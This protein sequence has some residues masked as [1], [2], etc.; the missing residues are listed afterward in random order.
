MRELISGR[1]PSIDLAWEEVPDAKKSE[2]VPFGRQGAAGDGEDD[3]ELSLSSA[4]V[5]LVR[6]SEASLDQF[7]SRLGSESDEPHDDDGGPPPEKTRIEA[8]P[9]ET[10]KQ[11]EAQAARS[12]SP[13]GPGSSP[14]TPVPK[15]S[16]TGGPAR[17]PAPPTGPHR[18]SL[19]T[20]G[21]G[22]KYGD[23]A[24]IPTVIA[25]EKDGNT[26]PPMNRPSAAPGSRTPPPVRTEA[27]Y[28]P[29]MVHAAQSES[30]MAATQAAV[31][32]DPQHGAHGG[33]GAMPRPSVER[34][35]A[36]SATHDSVKLSPDQ[37]A[38]LDAP[39]G[40]S[41]QGPPPASPYP[42]VS[43][44]P[45]SSELAPSTG[46]S[47]PGQHPRT[48]PQFSGQQAA[49]LMSPVGDHYP[50]ADWA[51]AAAAPAKALTRVQLALLFVA[52]VTAALVVTMMIAKIFH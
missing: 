15:D 18:P 14:R 24:Q 33:P 23:V 3:E 8:N 6:S 51:A 12:S 7:V 30:S 39:G 13:R 49:N 21:S 4:D 11:L 36:H 27:A 32:I 5:L 10:I 43:G 37:L 16:V 34:I 28:K 19:Q 41:G 29:T 42:V 40:P 47:G 17:L 46:R 45:S 2:T 20:P 9:L 31:P 1:D 52:A 25:D 44:R 48:G 26:P 50:Q 22:V 35:G 38:Q